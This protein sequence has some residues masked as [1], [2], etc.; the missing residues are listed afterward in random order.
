MTTSSRPDADMLLR[1]TPYL[2]GDG[3]EAQDRFA[4]VGDQAVR[5]RDRALQ[6]A[7]TIAEKAS[8]VLPQ[9]DL[10]V[11]SDLVAESNRMEGIDTSPRQIR[12][13]ARVRKELLEAE[14]SGFLAHIREDPRVLESLGLY[15]AYSLADDWSR[16]EKRPREFELRQL[17]ALVM[18]TLPSGGNY[19]AARNMIRGSKHVPTEPWSVRHEMSELAAWFVE[20][21]DDPV[22]DATVVHAWLTHI[23][24]FDDGNGRMARLL[25]NLALIQAHYPPL[26]LRSGSDRGQYLDALA[27]SDDGDILPLYDIFVKSLLRVVKT[28]EK[29]NFVES[30]IRDELL[31]TTRQRYLAWHGLADAFFMSME[32][33]AR[34]AG[35]QVRL[36]GYPTTED[37]TL[38]EDRSPEGNC[39]FAKFRYHAIDE[40]LLWFGYRSAEM[41]Q[42]LGG[43]TMWPS[44]FFAQR[45]E[46]PRAVH[47]FDTRFHANAEWNR[48]AEICFSPGRQRPVTV[49]WDHDTSEMHTD[50]AAACV[51]RAIC[52]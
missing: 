51:V 28:M 12:D 38:L 13:L 31:A 10:A 30:K 20:G 29:P 6:A 33:K 3:P 4:T 14:V 40:W 25:A 32:Q 15:R 24:P 16:S 19:K 37:F 45:T 18:P 44:V 48:P 35:W 50:E 42:T 26:L 17:H 21:T 5:V 1:G 39:W 22:L 27:A 8:A 34:R 2:I 46:D 9:F 52:R 41:V 11:R 43:R 7:A 23:H 49:R 47:P 36:M